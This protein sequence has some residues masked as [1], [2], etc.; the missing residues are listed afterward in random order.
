MI[1]KLLVLDPS[2]RLGANEKD[3]ETIKQHIFFQNCTYTRNR[4][5]RLASETQVGNRVPSLIDL[6]IRTCAKRIKH[7]ALSYNGYEHSNRF[8]K[9][10]DILKVTE[11]TKKIRARVMHTLDRM[12]C[13]SNVRVRRHFYSNKQDMRL[14]IIRYVS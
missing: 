11:N 13:I 4:V 10:T 1:S 5:G 8:E 6:C 2:K 3:K 9:I 14:K 12:F 7:D